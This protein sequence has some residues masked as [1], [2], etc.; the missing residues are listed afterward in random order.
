MGL[1]LDPPPA[2]L[3]VFAWSEPSTIPPVQ[4]GVFGLNKDSQKI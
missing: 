3:L 4:I 2:H 1:D